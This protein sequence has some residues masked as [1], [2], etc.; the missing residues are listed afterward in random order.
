MPPRF[1][2]I[3]EGLW[4]DSKLEGSSFEEHGFFAFLCS[5][6]RQ[7]P[8]GIYRAT[9]KQLAADTDLPIH[10][11]QEYL[12]DLTERTRIVRDGSWVFVKNYLKRQPHQDRLLKGVQNDL[13]NCDSTTILEAFSQQYPLYSKWST[14]RLLQ[15]R[16][17]VCTNPNT[18]TTQPQP[19]IQTQGNGNGFDPIL[20]S[21]LWNIHPGPKGSKTKA[22]QECRRVRPPANVV[23]LFARQVAYKEACVRKGKFCP[24]FQHLHRW[25]S[26]KRWEDDIPVLPE[27][28]AERLWREAQEEKRDE[29]ERGSSG[30]GGS[31]QSGAS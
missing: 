13:D 14:D 12:K 30:L 27:S 3:E 22:E 4:S 23:D 8:S 5:N 17:N 18:N 10:R 1:H 20:F 6:T 16:T 25:L 26:N 7:R 31:V 24:E 15:M 19:Q 21:A 11:V 9:D 29:G 28:T 2:P